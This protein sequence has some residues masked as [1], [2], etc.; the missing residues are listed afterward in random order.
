VIFAGYG[1]RKVSEKN[2]K[3]KVFLDA[4]PGIKSRITSTFYFDSYSPEEM[5]E[6]FMRIAKTQNYKVD[7]SVGPMIAEHFKTR[8]DDDNFGNGREAR[9]LLETSVLFAASRVLQEGK[10]KYT[11]EE[12]QTITR[13][14]VAAAIAQVNQGERIRNAGLGKRIGFN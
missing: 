11:K 3:M 9:S 6:I 13:E 10:T 8:V 14:D 4:N 2:N 7:A 5:V 12:M 1:G